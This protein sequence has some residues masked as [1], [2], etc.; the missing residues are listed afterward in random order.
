MYMIRNKTFNLKRTQYVN[1]EWISEFS[2][3]NKDG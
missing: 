1:W 2:M 3:S